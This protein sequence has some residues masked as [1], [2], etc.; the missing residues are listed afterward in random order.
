MEVFQYNTAGMYIGKTTADISPLE[1]GVYLIPANS[2]DIAVPDKWGDD[3][4]PRFSGQGWELIAR[5]TIA[6]EKTA[7]EK[8]AEFLEQNP[9]VQNLINK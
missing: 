8:L 6:Q 7:V 3:Q 2:T 4:W 5:P 9:D 1:P